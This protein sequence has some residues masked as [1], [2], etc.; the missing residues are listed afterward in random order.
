MGA[1]VKP[2]KQDDEE[3]PQHCGQVYAQEQDK[4]HALLLWPVG[5]PQEEELRYVCLVLR[6]H[7]VFYMLGI[8]G[9]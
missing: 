3:V 4:E 1:R 7:I 5:E 6:S 8:K 2:D 9:G